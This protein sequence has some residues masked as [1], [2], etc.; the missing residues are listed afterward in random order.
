[1]QNL[2]T[3]PDLAIRINA[4]E[5]NFV[6]VD[7]NLRV[8][9]GIITESISSG[10]A[11]DIIINS[12]RFNLTNG[13]GIGT[14]SYTSGLSGLIEIN[15][16]QSFK[17]SGTSLDFFRPS[18]IGSINLNS[19]SQPIYIISPIIWLNEGALIF[20]SNF[21]DGKA[22]DINIIGR[23]LNLNKGSSIF[24]NAYGGGRTGNLQINIS[25]RTVLSGVIPSIDGV[26]LSF[27]LPEAIQNLETSSAIYT[28]GLVQTST[29]GNLFLKTEKLEL[30]DGGAISSVITQGQGER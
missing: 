20:S 29:A 14:V 4:K 3:L 11:G 16:S 18:V 15:A 9:S 17:S 1:M 21:L 13:G 10:K 28:A 7:P 2:G 5:V 8:Q 26:V 30:L 19:Q 25:E 12:E 24:S 23:Q 6:G 27:G 22:A